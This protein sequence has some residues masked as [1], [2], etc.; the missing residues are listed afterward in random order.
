MNRITVSSSLLVIFSLLLSGCSSLISSQASK[1]A[2]N[3]NTAITQSEDIATVE[4]ASPTFIVL[5][6]S[7]IA[8][9]PDDP[10]LLR[11]GAAMYSTYAGLFVADP[12][13]KQL[14]AKQAF[15][16]AS[17]SICL[18]HDTLCQP[19]QLDVN[20]L[21]T[22][23]DQ[24]GPDEVDNLYVFGTSWLG[25]IQAN[26]GDWNAVADLAR[27]QKVLERVTQ[28]QADY[29]CGNSYLYLG[30]LH[31]LVPAA[32]GG[33]PELAKQYFEQA[34][35]YCDGQNQMARVVYAERYARSVFDREL[36]HQL[37]TAVMNAPVDQIPALTLSNSIA[38]Q[39]AR[40]LLADEDDY[41]F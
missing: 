22:A 15:H 16:Y 33:K 13:R 19:R 27:A 29:E 26:S 7:L 31:T 23:L 2:G 34:M 12:S 20:Q 32:L 5:M 37:L 28:L 14:M 38:K 39:R 35:Q 9:S 21:Q 41:F 36:H 8:G 17:E 6:D 30:A 11:Q 4:Q 3:I 10:A 40:E 25:W 18:Q 1:F 24:L